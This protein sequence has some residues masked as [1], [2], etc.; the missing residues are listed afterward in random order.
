MNLKKKFL[1]QAE[2]VEPIL[3][4]MIRGDKV[5]GFDVDRV[6]DLYIKSGEYI[7][8]ARLYASCFGNKAMMEQIDKI[9]EIARKRYE[10]I[11]ELIS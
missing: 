4:G 2:L 5:E 1:K 7:L 11:V 10:K 9:E 3:N 6:I 8:A